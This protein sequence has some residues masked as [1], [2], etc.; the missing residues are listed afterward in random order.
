MTQQEQNQAQR[1]RGTGMRRALGIGLL[2]WA[3]GLAS[4]HCFTWSTDPVVLGLAAINVLRDVGAVAGL[5]LA[6]FAVG[7][8]LMAL[9]RLEQRD[10]ITDVAAG[11]ALYLVLTSVLGFLGQLHSWLLVSLMLAGVVSNLPAVFAL[12][13]GF[14]RRLAR[15][16]EGDINGGKLVIAAL[17]VCL[18]LAILVQ[19]LGPSSGPDDLIYHVNNAVRFLH[20]HST[21]LT[22]ET[23]N[24][25]AMQ[26]NQMLY[27][28][29]LAVSGSEVS[30]KVMNFAM[31]LLLL[32]TLGLFCRRFFPRVSPGLVHLLLLSQPVV[33][34]VS[35]RPY[36]D[37]IISWLTTLAV[38]H[39]ALALEQ[40]RRPQL[41]LSA[42]FM[43]LA[44]GAKISVLAALVAL[45][46][47]VMAAFVVQKWRGLRGAAL[48]LLLCGGVVLLMVLPWHL[49]MWIHLDTPID[50]LFLGA[51]WVSPPEYML[52][53]SFQTE[54]FGHLRYEKTLENLLLLPFF[55]TFSQEPPNGFWGNILSPAYLCLLPL[56]LLCCRGR[57]VRMFLALQCSIYLAIWAVNLS[58]IRYLLPIL[59]LASLLCIDALDEVG[60]RLGRPMGRTVVAAVVVTVMVLPATAQ[61]FKLALD[62]VSRKSL[63]YSADLISR[64]EF[65]RGTRSLYYRLYKVFD[66][67]NRRLDP[68]RARVRIFWDARS[69]HLRIP[70]VPDTTSH[71]D[72][73]EL[74]RLSGWSDAGFL[75]TLRARRFTHIIYNAED[76]HNLFEKPGAIYARSTA[77]KKKALR[78]NAAFVR[79]AKRHLKLVHREGNIVLF[80]LRD[81]GP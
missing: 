4:F 42:L 1:D 26:Y 2:L 28:L 33:I 54:V 74:Q 21:A 58:Y 13:R 22:P 18:L 48:D 70:H 14:H 66:H 50:P 67:C 36:G 59:P 27:L 25:H 72:L 8:R 11:M 45:L 10:P 5:L 64:E 9:L 44:L 55:V 78:A 15:A 6:F 3:L 76:F 51:R 49:W 37:N 62:P 57:K 30:A 19:N 81:A 41:L 61:L 24:F 75:R 73:Y 20:S 71:S 34:Y 38:Y 79:F 29:C 16:L 35:V 65:Y 12:I 63:L 7:Q 23:K 56:V 52:E 77:I 68:Q 32:G 17:P 47:A 40:R 60:R 31:L 39:A 53:A 69:Q 46:V 80:E 43:G